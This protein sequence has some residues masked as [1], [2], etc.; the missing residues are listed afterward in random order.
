MK[1]N[2]TAEQV[3]PELSV[4]LHRRLASGIHGNV[5]EGNAARLIN[6]LQTVDERPPLYRDSPSVIG[7]ARIRFNHLGH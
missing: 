2:H 6:F 3:A 7:D 4:K 1:H 5:A